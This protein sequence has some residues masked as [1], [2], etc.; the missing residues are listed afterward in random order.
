VAVEV[1]LTAVPDDHDVRHLLRLQDRLGVD[2]L[3]MVIV[4]TGTDAYRRADGVAV[5]PAALLGRDS[6]ALIIRRRHPHHQG[7][8]T[9]AGR[10]RACSALRNGR[11]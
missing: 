1:K 4:A 7:D 11:V 6:A 3:D 9:M 8:R 10:R 5:V 2:L